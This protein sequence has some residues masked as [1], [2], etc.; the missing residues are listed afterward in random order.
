[1]FGHH[2]NK[3]FQSINYNRVGFKRS[4]NAISYRNGIGY[5][6]GLILY[7]IKV[8]N[9]IHVAIDKLN[10]ISYSLSN[11]KGNM[12]T[13]MKN[14]K[15][16][17]VFNNFFF[18]VKSSNEITFISTESINSICLLSKTAEKTYFISEFNVENEHD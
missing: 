6:F 8:F 3:I 18:H 16:I 4:N 2:K 11:I 14:L 1:M 7:F 5:S 9:K 13:D 10:I 12:N 15:N 17:G